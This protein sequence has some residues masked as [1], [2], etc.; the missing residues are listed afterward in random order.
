M[1]TICKIKCNQEYY[2]YCGNQHLD[3]WI[4]KEVG[5]RTEFM[6]TTDNSQKSLCVTS[7]IMGKYR[8]SLKQDQLMISPMKSC[9]CVTV[10]IFS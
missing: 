1:E 5:N 2:K 4:S 10:V 7:K 6:L 8:R 3:L 9:L